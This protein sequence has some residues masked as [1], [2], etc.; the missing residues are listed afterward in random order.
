M[1]D[2]VESKNSYI[3]LIDYINF[4]LL[5]INFVYSFLRHPVDLFTM[6]SHYSNELFGP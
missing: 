6:L 1:L 2:C 4:K 3:L 5:V